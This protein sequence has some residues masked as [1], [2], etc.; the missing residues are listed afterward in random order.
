MLTVGVSFGM[1]GLS[2][3]YLVWAVRND[4]P[5]QSLAAWLTNWVFVVTFAPLPAI[6]LLFPTGR[7][8][9]PRWRI[10]LYAIAVG[11]AALAISSWIRPGEVD[12]DTP[13]A[14]PTGV[15]ALEPLSALLASVGSIAI[16]AG[17]LA[18]VVA[19]VLRY[20][21]SV[22][23]ERRQIRA[24]AFVAGGSVVLLVG[25]FVTSVRATNRARTC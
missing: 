12:A 20:R 7:V 14:N 15:E 22:D 21:T 2:D 4:A 17:A 1:I 16:I 6:L 5:L 11:A 13:F 18:A 23:V 25:S 24:L 8:L 10:V 9:S 3:E 19:L